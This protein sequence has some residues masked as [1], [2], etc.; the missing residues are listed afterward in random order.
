MFPKRT[1]GCRTGKG[2]LG[3]QLF[4]G[5]ALS[6]PA[7]RLAEQPVDERR[8]MAGSGLTGM[9]EGK[10]LGVTPAMLGLVT[11]DTGHGSRRRPAGIPE[12]LLPESDLGGRQRII[13]R[14]GGEPC[15]QSEREP[16]R[17]QRLRRTAP[18]P[19]LPQCL[20]HA[21]CQEEEG[22][23]G[24][25]PPTDDVQASLHRAPVKLLYRTDLWRCQTALPSLRL[26][27]TSLL[28]RRVAGL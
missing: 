13:R 14:H 27:A 23:Q 16:E 5:R 3:E 25:H 1:D 6:G 21:P 20:A 12:Q 17:R 28:T 22:T 24:P 10:T 2:E 4:E 26:H 8:R 15:D 19:R 7:L 11:T 18:R 9:I